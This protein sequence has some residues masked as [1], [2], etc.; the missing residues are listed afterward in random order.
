MSL[1]TERSLGQIVTENLSRA[2]VLEGFGIDY[3]SDGGRRLDQA[4]LE[5]SLDPQEV[6]VALKQAEATA[7]ASQPDWASAPIDAITAHIVATHHAY[8]RKILPRLTFLVDKIATVHGSHHPELG[9]LSETF[10]RFVQ[11]MEAHIEKEES[12]FFPRCQELATSG[13]DGLEEFVREA[14]QAHEAEHQESVDAFATMRRLTNGFEVPADSCN[15]Y[16][17]TFEKLLELEADTHMHLHM[18]NNVLFG[19]LKNLA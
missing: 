7:E 8:L 19:R 11:S 5:L 15:T 16:Q 13:A 1:T 12:L 2:V 3:Y 14:I 6:L 10:Q 4:C 9:A 18:E 17:M